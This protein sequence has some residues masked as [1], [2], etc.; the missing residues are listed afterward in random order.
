MNRDELYRSLVCKAVVTMV[1][2]FFLSEESQVILAGAP[3]WFVWR[4][5]DGGRRASVA[6][7]CTVTRDEALPPQETS[8]SETLWLKC[9]FSWDRGRGREGSWGPVNAMK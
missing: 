1:P 9:V 8:C 7:R 3:V 2:L 4:D 5:N 6:Q